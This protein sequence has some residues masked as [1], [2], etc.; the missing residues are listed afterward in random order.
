M[1]GHAER[2]HRK[3]NIMAKLTTIDTDKEKANQ[4]QWTW[5]TK[6]QTWSGEFKVP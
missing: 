3:K 1:A 5:L 4:I 2:S 6:G